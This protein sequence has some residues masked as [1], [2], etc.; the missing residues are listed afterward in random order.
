[1]GMGTRI[2]FPGGDFIVRDKDKND[3]WQDHKQLPATTLGLKL[4]TKSM[5]IF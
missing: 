3:V 5:Q 1:M 2:F 4:R